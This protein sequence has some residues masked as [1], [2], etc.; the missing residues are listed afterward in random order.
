[1]YNAHVT[2]TALCLSQEKGWRKNRSPAPKPSLH[3]AK[4]YKAVAMSCRL[5]KRNAEASFRANAAH[6]EEAWV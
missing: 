1:M 6:T 3:T 5:V 2:T 4:E